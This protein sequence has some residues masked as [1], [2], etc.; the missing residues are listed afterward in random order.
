MTESS[1]A[2]SWTEEAGKNSGW[3]IALGVIQIIVG[4]LAI[5]SPM[6][7]GIAAT[8]L[9]GGFLV[10]AGIMRIIGA[11]KCAS[12]GAGVFAFL[13]GLLATVAGLMFVARP[14]IA[15]TTLTLFLAV[16]FFA[17]G[18]S[19]VILGFHV[20]PDKGWGWLVFDGVISVLLGLLIGRQWPL[21]GVWA[22][23]TL[24]GIHILISGWS[25]LM[26]GL[27]VRASG[28]A[29]SRP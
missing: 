27:A 22:V 4:A 12:F 28:S 10:V 1:A 7:S 11:F 20:K 13:W 14:G 26:I 5:G 17:S 3:L 6:V 8:L 24:V 21:S 16:Y 23:G 15:L 18:I 25:E 2:A 29:S 19:G 9:V